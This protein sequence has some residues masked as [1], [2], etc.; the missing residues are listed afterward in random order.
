MIEALSTNRKSTGFENGNGDTRESCLTNSLRRSLQTLNAAHSR[1]LFLHTGSHLSRDICHPGQ[2]RTVRF[3][4]LI[5][6]PPQPKSMTW[7]SI[8]SVHLQTQ[9][10]TSLICSQT[11]VASSWLSAQEMTHRLWH[12]GQL[13]LRFS[14]FS[15]VQHALWPSLIQR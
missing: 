10:D 8:D 3:V 11:S 12:E 4:S 14:V 9:A 7:Y 15:A 2:G 13:S 1:C 6:A 5:R